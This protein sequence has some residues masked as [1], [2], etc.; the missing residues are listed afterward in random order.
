MLVLM[1][2]RVIAFLLNPF[3][4]THHT[5][6]RETSEFNFSMYIINLDFY[7]VFYNYARHDFSTMILKG[8]KKRVRELFPLEQFKVT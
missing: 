6:S 1:M 2:M 8:S 7:Y 5:F 4:K 3:R